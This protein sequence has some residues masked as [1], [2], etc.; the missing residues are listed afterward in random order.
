MLP[1]KNAPA[2]GADTAAGGGAD[3]GMKKLQDTIDGLAKG[4]TTG[5]NSLAARIQQMEE[6]AKRGPVKTKKQ[7]D[8][9][10]DDDDDDG[11]DNLEALTNAQL[12]KKI[13]A[14][15]LKIIKPA[16]EQVDGVAD[17]AVGKEMAEAVKQAAKDHPDFW[18]WKEEI[19]AL[20]KKKPSLDPE[21]LYTLVRNKNPDKA[22]ELDGKAKKAAAKK[23]QD[24]GEDVDDEGE[25]RVPFGG[26][27][28]TS[29][30]NRSAKKMNVAEAVEDAWQKTM[31]QS[32]IR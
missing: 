7:A 13:E 10:D 20:A 1:A 28:P 12:L 2:K 31:G 27:T 25:P 22:V 21:E 19:A 8:D 18:E 6:T 5:M 14:R 16:L 26:L 11:D 17:A 30:R 9:A 23:K 29:G 24:A 32:G 15:V 4:F 3:D